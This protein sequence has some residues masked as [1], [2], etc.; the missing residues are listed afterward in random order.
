[1][2]AVSFTERRAQGYYRHELRTLTYV[3]IDGGNGGIIRNINHEGVAV[4][5]VGALHSEQR[6]RLRFELRFPRLRIDAYGQV[7]WASPTGQCGIQFLDFPSSTGLQLNQWIFSNLL[8]AMAREASRP[9]SIFTRSMY[10]NPVVPIARGSASGEPEEDG[11]RVSAA[12]REEIQLQ[13]VIAVKEYQDALASI[14]CEEPNQLEEFGEPGWLSHPLA[15]RSL[16]YIVDGLVVT[17]ALL[18]FAFIFLSIT[19]EIPPWPL[20]LLT[21]LATAAFVTGSYC[22]MFMMFRGASLGQ[23]LAR[24]NGIGE[25]VEEPARIRQC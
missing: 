9:Q 15:S 12:A 6:V 20:A 19:H 14:N 13:P 21:G 17:A 8:D 3:T 11:L 16:A 22:S 2:Q 18:I 5:A 4:Q 25:V 7:T 24:A 23:V 10:G 1:M